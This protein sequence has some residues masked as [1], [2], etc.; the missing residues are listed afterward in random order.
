MAPIRSAFI[1]CSQQLHASIVDALMPTACKQVVDDNPRQQT[2]IS[3]HAFA[4][5]VGLGRYI[6]VIGTLF[7][8][9][10]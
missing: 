8:C 5:D 9:K 2:S 4:V 6:K 7:V 10:A 3:G 1:D